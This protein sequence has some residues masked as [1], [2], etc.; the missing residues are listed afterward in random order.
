MLDIYDGP[1]K[2]THQQG[3]NQHSRQS[4][5]RRKTYEP[6]CIIDVHEKCE[7]ECIIDL[8]GDLNQYDLVKHVK[9]EKLVRR[10]HDKM[11]NI[12][13]GWEDSKKMINEMQHNV[14]RK[15]K[16]MRDN[17]R[18]RKSDEWD[19]D[20]YSCS[21]QDTLH[22]CK[23]CPA[24]VCNRWVMKYDYHLTKKILDLRDLQISERELC[25]HS[26]QNTQWCNDDVTIGDEW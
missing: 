7:L 23:E 21:D 17:K 13:D 15:K 3:A 8:V 20:C 25:P 6:E 24:G 4:N 16:M 19:N 26:G 10:R 1:R 2:T 12:Y 11:S 9:E 22:L 18:Q 14:A 5:I